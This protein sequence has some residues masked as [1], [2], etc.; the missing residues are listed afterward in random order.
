MEIEQLIRTLRANLLTVAAVFLLCLAAGTAAAVLPAKQYTATAVVLLQPV[1]GSA[2]ISG[3]IV[4]I[5]YLLPQLPTEATDP[6][7]LIRARSRVPA[8]EA[9]AQV[10]VSAV[11]D[12]GTGILQISATSGSGGVA[13][14]YAN[15]LAAHMIAVVATSSSGRFAVLAQV[16]PV[17]PP[18][19]PSNPRLPLLAG[20]AAFGVIAGIFAGIGAGALR[21]RLSRA[22]EVRSRAGVTVLAEIPRVRRHAVDP[23][24]VFAED[25]DAL[26]AEAFQELRSSILLGLDRVPRSIAVT[27]CEEGEGKTTVAAALAWAL[28]S[29]GRPVVAVDCDLRRPRLHQVLGVPF[30]RGLAGSRGTDVLALATPTANPDLAV[31]PAGVPDRHP[32][33]VL[34]GVLPGVLEGLSGSGRLAVLDCPPLGG[35]AET[36]IAAAAADVI[37]MVVDTASFDPAVLQN[38]L[39]RLENAGSVVVGVVLNRVRVGRRQRRRSYQYLSAVL[40]PQEVELAAAPSA[41]A[42]PGWY[43]APS[44]HEPEMQRYWDGGRWTHHVAVP[45]SRGRRAGTPDRTPAD[46]D[47]DP[48]P[49]ANGT[50]PPTPVRKPMVRP[51]PRRSGRAGPD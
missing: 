25:G 11:A 48:A 3:D 23:A 43:P 50:P 30:G 26:A 15:A 24:D 17:L 21:R 42:L 35:L 36:V 18:G 22:E 38:A 37:V 44:E 34:L 40:S 4:A 47:A 33:D 31:V 5:Q 28:A 7:S 27:S 2:D 32:A 41:A 19:S 29:D 49:P 1:P 10:S 46:L 51:G 16:S 6:S 45:T 14:D 12:P 20:S 13:A 8:G 39:L 9:R